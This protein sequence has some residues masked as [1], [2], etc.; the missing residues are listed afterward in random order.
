MLKGNVNKIRFNDFSE[1]DSEKC[2]NGGRYGFWTQYDRIEGE[3]FEVTYGTTADFAYC[4]CCG[5]FGDHYAAN[6]DQDIYDSG[7]TCGRI[8]TISETEMAELIANFVETEDKYIEY[9]Q[10]EV[11]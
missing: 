5:S 6:E 8:E 10:P 9:P 1:Y 2:R 7:F 11:Y 3:V 4:P